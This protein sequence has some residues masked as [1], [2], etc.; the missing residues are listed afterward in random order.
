MMPQEQ[1]ISIQSIVFETRFLVFIETAPQ[2]NIYSQILLTRAQ[3]KALGDLVQGIVAKPCEIP[4]HIHM[5]NCMSIPVAT[6]KR[7]ST[8]FE[9][10]SFYTDEEIAKME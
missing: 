1:K 10:Q 6:S 7:V 8:P 4:N 9:I 5:P 3:F 2:S